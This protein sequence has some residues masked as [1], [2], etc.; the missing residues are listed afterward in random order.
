MT[1]FREHLKEQMKDP[2]FREAWD[3]S[4]LSYQVA[5]TL[6]KLRLDLDLTQEEL[7]RRAGVTQSVIARL[8]S[9]RHLPSLRS[10]DRIAK[11]PGLGV[12]LDL[13]PRAAVM[14]DAPVGG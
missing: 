14:G 8:E 11:K 13:V 10:L 6:I 7:A 12:R 5:R 1:T 4:E 3:E 9:G 2:A